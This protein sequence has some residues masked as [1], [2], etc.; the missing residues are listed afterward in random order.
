MDKKGPSYTVET[1]AEMRNRVYENDELFFLL[2]W[3]NLEKIVKW[4][5]PERL[6]TLCRLVAIPRPGYS[7]P[8]L[9][10]LEKE[11]PG[12]KEKTTMMAGPIID[13]SASEI[14]E[15]AAKGKTIDDLVPP[16][17]ADYIRK[18]NLYIKTKPVHGK[19]LDID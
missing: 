3:D 9:G 18:N 15:K 13:I 1:L 14:R 2:G 16:K 8:S 10:K 5:D 7:K 11:L 19:M 4:K 6:L 17:V 12:I